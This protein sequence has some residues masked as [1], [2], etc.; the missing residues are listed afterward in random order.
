MPELHIIE[1]KMGM[2]HEDVGEIK[3]TLKS[4]TEAITKLA[5]VEARQLQSEAAIDRAFKAIEKVEFKVETLNKYAGKNNIT[6]EWV[7]RFV[8]AIVAAAGVY[9]LK[10]IKVI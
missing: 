2:L 6:S 3:Q 4:L 7:Q 8:W 5:L 1:A 9:L 10:A